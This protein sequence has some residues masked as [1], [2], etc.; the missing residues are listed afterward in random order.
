MS[1][2]SEQSLRRSTEV[3]NNIIEYL[4]LTLPD[5]MLQVHKVLHMLQHLEVQLL[6]Y[7]DFLAPALFLETTLNNENEM[8][9]LWAIK[10][11][12]SQSQIV[13]H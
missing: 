12:A 7:S 13:A 5:Q 4:P 10:L 11:I 3:S 6:H 8:L 9:K 1:S 2:V